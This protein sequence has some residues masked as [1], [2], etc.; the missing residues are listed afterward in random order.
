MKDYKDFLI[1][2]DKIKKGLIDNGK[3]SSFPFFDKCNLKNNSLVIIGGRTGIGK[4]TFALN[5]MKEIIK[6]NKKIKVLYFSLEMNKFEIFSR[7]T[8]LTTGIELEKIACGDFNF[9]NVAE[10]M[11]FYKDRLTVID[12][13]FDINNIIYYIKEAKES[14]PNLKVIFIDYLGLAVSYDSDRYFKFGKATRNLHNIAKALNLCVISLNQ[15]NRYADNEEVPELIHLRD[16]GTIE[17]DAEQ[18]F[19][20]YEDK[21]GLN[22]KI[23]KNRYGISGICHKLQFNKDKA[24]IDDL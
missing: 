9:H 20:L 24:T 16:S 2:L 22:I 10:T 3:I 11:K 5:L 21:E 4:T 13:A 7:L 8:A 19:L 15:L 14:D 18:V 1:L 12:S 6:K 23:A 17:Q